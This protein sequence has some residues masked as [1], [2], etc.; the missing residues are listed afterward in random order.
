MIMIIVIIV[1]PGGQ[2]SEERALWPRLRFPSCGSGGFGRDTALRS[3]FRSRPRHAFL[4]AIA[5]QM[6]RI[7]ALGSYK[8]HC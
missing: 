7:R 5:D 8:V 3:L 1:L 6:D 4:A 2:Y